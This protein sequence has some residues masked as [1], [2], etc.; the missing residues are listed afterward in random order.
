MAGKKISPIDIEVGRR[1]RLYRLNAGISQKRLSDQIGVTFQQ[2]QKYEKGVN[3]VGAGQ[4]THIANALGVPVGA[5]F[6]TVAQCD[7]TSEVNGS[8][9]GSHSITEL[10]TLPHA[11]RLLQA[12]SSISDGG[13]QTALV[14]FAEALGTGRASK[15]GQH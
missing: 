7:A 2:V 5:F 11:L 10:L 3:R 14:Q 15:F 13:T 4:L 12:Y 6:E 8:A 9:N 1:I